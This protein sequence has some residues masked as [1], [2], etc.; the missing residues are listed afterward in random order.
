MPNS[1]GG[2]LLKRLEQK[3]PMLTRLSG[4]KVRLVES[5][6][7]PLS[8]LFSLDI[9]DGKCHRFD[10]YVCA[11]HQGKSGSKCR[12]KSIVYESRCMSC[13]KSNQPVYIGESGRSLYERALE[14]IDDAENQ[15]KCSHIFKHW[16]LSHPEMESRPLFKF[17]VLKSHKAPLDRQLHEAVRISTHG[18]LNSKAECH[19]NQ[20]KRLAVQLTPR[21]MKTMEKELTKEDKVTEAA[22]ESLSIKLKSNKSSTLSHVSS[23]TSSISDRVSAVVF[24]GYSVKRKKVDINQSGCKRL[25][26]GRKSKGNS[27]NESKNLSKIIPGWSLD[28]WSLPTE[29][30]RSPKTPSTFAEASVL[31]KS[32]YRKR[33]RGKVS[34]SAMSS[35]MLATSPSFSDINL[36]FNIQQ[37]SLQTDSS[38]GS[39]C[40][41]NAVTPNSSVSATLSPMSNI[42]KEQEGGLSVCLL[43]LTVNEDISHCSNSDSFSSSP[44]SSQNRGA[45]AFL[46]LVEK[47]LQNAATVGF[48][49]LIV[50]MLDLE[51]GERVS[52]SSQI[53]DLLNSKGW[54]V[55]QV[56][57]VWSV[58]PTM[59]HSQYW[60]VDTLKRLGGRDIFGKVWHELRDKK[61][62]GHHKRAADEDSSLSRKKRRTLDL[63]KGS[64]TGTHVVN[65]IILSNSPVVLPAIGS[66]NRCSNNHSTPSCT[67]P[68]NVEDI[69]QKRRMKKACRR[70]Y[71]ATPKITEWLLRCPTPSQPPS[72]PNLDTP[73]SILSTQK[74]KKKRNRRRKSHQNPSLPA[75]TKRSQEVSSPQS[76]STAVVQEKPVQVDGR[77]PSSMSPVLRARRRSLENSA[78]VL[79]TDQLLQDENVV[80]RKE[81]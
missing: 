65:P 81:V 27:L 17:T 15:R 42:G 35:K 70:G 32:W 21:E 20:I 25:N 75:D 41:V 34:G 51:V 80:A 58:G 47:A 74:P 19:Q 40:N 48:E 31:A 3:E 62:A 8:R 52:T 18:K 39:P 26:M 4:F 69:P 64:G 54:N 43:N 29:K 60:D 67:N 38:T 33:E 79:S 50:Q 14:H 1:N 68:L 30:L 73:P 77:R 11:L 7:I 59:D 61:M 22:V 49:D 10:C 45:I 23:I 28:E 63:N 9:S 78:A 55:Q 37:V 53:P 66:P 13:P 76:H 12:K 72:K 24:T 56:S 36:S 5:S 57:Q 2:T 16:A 46:E 6:G 71:L 44:D